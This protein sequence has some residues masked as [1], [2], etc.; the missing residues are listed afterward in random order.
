MIHRYSGLLH[1]AFAFRY[2]ERSK[3]NILY[4]YG[5][6]RIYKKGIVWNG[7][8]CGVANGSASV[9]KRR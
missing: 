2:V 1:T 6:K 9:F 3:R 4:R 7:I 5:Q 8:Y